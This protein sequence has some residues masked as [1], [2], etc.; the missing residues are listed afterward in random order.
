MIQELGQLLI[1]VL[2][3]DVCIMT[4]QSQEHNYIFFFARGVIQQSS[5]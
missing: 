4:T 2:D 5:M 3:E 1:L